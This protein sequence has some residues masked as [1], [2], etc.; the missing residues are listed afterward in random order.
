MKTLLALVVVGCVAFGN[1]VF[2]LEAATT[3]PESHQSSDSADKQLAVLRTYVQNQIN[4]VLTCQAKDK[5]YTPSTTVPGRD[6]DGCVVALDML[7]A[8]GTGANIYYNNGLVGINTNVPTEKL[9]VNGYV[10]VRSTN[11]EGGTIRL[12]GNNGLKVYV[13]NINGDFRLV[14]DPWN[15]EMLRIN[16]AG[17]LTVTGKIT[18]S[19]YNATSRNNDAAPS[20]WNVNLRAWD[21]M[22]AS[23][24]LKGGILF[25]NGTWQA[26]A[27]PNCP[28]THGFEVMAVVVGI[29]FKLGDRDARQIRIVARVYQTTNLF[30]QKYSKVVLPG[31]YHSHHV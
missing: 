4:Y 2:A 10:R 5:V 15:A 17:D 18:N 13:E 14:N 16:R 26:S 27:P 8:K 31:L 25:P 11:G 20:G 7:W 30:I 23:I 3:S 29:V 22:F 6:V 24:K 21:A 19:G 9:D 28:Y 12:D 1:S